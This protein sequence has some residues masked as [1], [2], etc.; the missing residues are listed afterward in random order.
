MATLRT[1]VDDQLRRVRGVVLSESMFGHGNAYWCNGKEIA[2]FEGESVLEVR[3][4]RAVI[5]ERRGKLEVDPRIELRPSGADWITVRL[6]SD[7]DVTF[8]VDVVRAA[9]KAHRPP[10]GQR[11]KPPPTGPDLERRRR[12]H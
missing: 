7:A 8:V 6:A 12:F 10:P 11:P 5:R 3:L 1:I 2:H 9:A 4:T